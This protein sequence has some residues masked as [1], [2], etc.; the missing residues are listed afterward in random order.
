M[1]GKGRSGWYWLGCMLY[2]LLLAVV[3]L[4]IRFP[5]A[6]V[7]EYIEKNF[8]TA[9]PGVRT[10][11]GTMSYSFPA[12]L[13]LDKLAVTRQSGGEEIAVLENISISP[14][15]TGLGLEYTLSGD[16]YGG[17][18]HS[19]LRLAPRTRVLTVDDVELVRVPLERSA[20]LQS[21]LQRDLRGALDF[22][23]S[24]I[25]SLAG[26]KGSTLQGRAVVHEGGFL[27][28]QPIFSLRE[29]N[30]ET[31]EFEVSYE[32]GVLKVL[33]GSLKGAELHAGFAGELLTI[34]RFEDWDIMI[35]G[36]MLPQQG[37][38]EQNRQVARVINRLQKQFRNNE[39]PYKLS[40]NIGSLRFR[41]GNE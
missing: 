36:D 2:A 28:R 21:V 40:G 31:M 12:T 32:A 9:I 23:G 35:E 14:V 34:G 29:I 18:F 1:E 30:M 39:L 37:F 22:H 13:H 15:P 7:Q 11:P 10:A 19:T 41:F 8:V 27:L 4:Y 38:T 25:V 33:D 20:V 6:K 16:L 24:C 5:A 17:N 3:L 26:K